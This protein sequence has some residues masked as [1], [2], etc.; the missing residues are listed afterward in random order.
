MKQ[1]HTRITNVLF[2]YFTITGTL[3]FIT[4]C[5]T[6]PPM[7]E[8]PVTRYWEVAEPLETV[9]KATVQSLV[10]KGVIISILDQEDHLIVAEEIL[11]E[12]NIRHLIAERGALEGGMARVTLLLT[13]KSGSRTGIQ[14]N[15]V[16][17]GYTGRYNVYATSNGNLEKDYYFSITNNLPTKKSYK[18][19]E[20]KTEGDNDLQR[21]EEQQIEEEA[22]TEEAT[23]QGPP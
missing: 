3:L 2:N 13:E 12:G 21:G 1:I 6:P 4:C 5:A 16:I 22:K 14:I 18:W 23:S 19:L 20:E 11:E 9:W 7:L 8:E 15:C 10:D 17:Q